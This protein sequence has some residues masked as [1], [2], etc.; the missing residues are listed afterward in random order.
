MTVSVEPNS[1]TFN[2]Y[3]FKYD[4]NKN[5]ITKMPYLYDTYTIKKKAAAEDSVSVKDAIFTIDE[6]AANG[7]TVGTVE[8]TDSNQHPLSYRI[9][10]GNEMGAFGM[11]EATGKIVVADASKLDYE[12]VERFT[13]TVQVS[14]EV[15]TAEAIVTIHVISG[16]VT[17]RQLTSS[18]GALN[19]A[20]EPGTTHYTM[21][22]GANIQTITFTP[23]T[24]NA[25]A[26]VKIN[27]KPV[28]SGHESEPI[29]LELGKNNM[30]IEVSAQNGQKATYTIEVTRLASGGTGH[31]S[32][33]RSPCNRFG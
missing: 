5:E 9:I 4:Q 18:H 25:Q 12:K 33:G 10:S 21:A 26:S 7:T 3:A 31:T 20:F 28:G 23:T 24:A 32:K 6:Q 30:I 16:D 19:P 1:V 27:G 2:T 8:A 14:D 29:A 13:L 15:T 11:D 22:V 17:L